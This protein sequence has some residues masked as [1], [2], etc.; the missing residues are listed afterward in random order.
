MMKGSGPL[1]D[2]PGLLIDSANKQKNIS[3]N[4]KDVYV[5]EGLV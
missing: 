1:F 5:Q 4:G 2:V 3:I